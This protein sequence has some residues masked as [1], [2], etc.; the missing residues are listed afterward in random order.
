MKLTTRSIE[1]NIAPITTSPPI[2]KPPK[3]AT[4]CPAEYRPWYPWLNIKRVV[5][6]SR[7]RRNNVVSNNNVGKDVKSN[8]FFKNN[9][10]IKTNI[11]NVTEIDKPIS[12]ANV[13]RGKISIKR[14]PAT[15]SAR[16]TSDPGSFFCINVKYGEVLTKLN[17]DSKLIEKFL[18]V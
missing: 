13:G 14:R 17:I 3:A 7:D 6:T 1:N 5:A 10:T 4:T 12:R 2:R 18:F 11:D 16:P 15:K 8:G 9:A